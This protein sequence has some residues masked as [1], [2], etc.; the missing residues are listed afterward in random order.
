M[1]AADLARE[2]RQVMREGVPTLDGGAR[3][4][5]LQRYVDY[6]P[7]V[8]SGKRVAEFLDRYIGRDPGLAPELAVRAPTTET[9]ISTNPALQASRH[10]SRV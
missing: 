2:V 7:D 3:L 5:L 1:S 9:E 6:S 4:Q 8:S 10:N